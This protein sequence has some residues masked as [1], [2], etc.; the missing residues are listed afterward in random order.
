MLLFICFI[1]LAQ[2][3]AFKWLIP[4]YHSLVANAAATTANFS[5]GYTYLLLLAAVIAALAA[6]IIVTTRKKINNTETVK[7]SLVK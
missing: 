6:V 5:R 7:P 3:Y 4:Q 2:A 1:V